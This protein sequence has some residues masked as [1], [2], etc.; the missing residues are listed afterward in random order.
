MGPHIVSRW[1][2]AADFVSDPAFEHGYY[3]LGGEVYQDMGNAQRTHEI[4]KSALL[5][6]LILCLRNNQIHGRVL[7]ET[8]YMLTDYT[9][10][11][12]DISIQLP[13]RSAGSG[14]F[15]GSPEIVIEILGAWCA[16]RMDAGPGQAQDIH[17]D[18]H[19][20]VDR[21][22]LSGSQRIPGRNGESV[23]AG[24]NTT[25]YFSAVMIRLPV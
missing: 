24:M 8:A 16:S 5:G 1:I 13:E 18:S 20:R 14:L 4:V 7:S 21:N 12:P 10:L 15:Q 22:G 9:V 2:T 23:A 17:R 3:I 6:A 25:H 11:I 19:G